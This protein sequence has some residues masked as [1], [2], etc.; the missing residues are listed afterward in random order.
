VQYLPSINRFVWLLQYRKTKK[1]L[2][3]LRLITFHPSDVD[4]NVINSWIYL[5]IASSDLKFTSWLDY[6][7]LAVGNSQLYVSATVIGSGLVVF[8]IPI[9]ALDIVG[10]LTYWYTNMNDG[11]VAQ[12]SRL[13]QNPGEHCFLGGPFLSR[14]DYAHIQM[15]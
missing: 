15:A 10:T 11:I 13:S 5:D 12:S 8:R 9:A 1:G 4:K 14:N 7:E 6:G 3:K 2:N